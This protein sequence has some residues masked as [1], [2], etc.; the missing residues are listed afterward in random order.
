MNKNTNRQ[1]K[2]N[3]NRSKIIGNA[4]IPRLSVFRSN[5]YIKAQLIDDNAGRTI[6]YID[7][8]KFP[9]DKKI[10]NMEYAFESGLK[11]GEEILAKKIT[12]IK[13]D[14]RWYKYHG[15]VK[16]FADGLRKAG[17]KF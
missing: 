6:A 10:K 3:K 5:K 11:L 8:K 13:F 12:N 9:K 17:I 4:K 2:I 7:Q 1:R 16:N 15:Q 14:R